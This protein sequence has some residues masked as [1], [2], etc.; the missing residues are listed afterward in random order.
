MTKSKPSYY[1]AT[2]AAYDVLAET[3]TYTAPIKVMPLFKKYDPS[4]GLMTFTKFSEYMGMSAELFA[5]VGPSKDGFTLLDRDSGLKIVVFNERLSTQRVRF[6]LAHELGHCAL[7]HLEDDEVAD[8]E[9]N[10]FARNLLCPLPLRKEGD[11]YSCAD[12]FQIS[13]EMAA[14]VND[15]DPLDQYHILSTHLK[16]FKRYND[17]K[18]LF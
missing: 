17:I 15:F 3:E 4:I 14:A 13:L 8:L 7:G 5:E 16:R 6:T 2:N 1:V 12:R 10:C 9:A 11:F 18:G